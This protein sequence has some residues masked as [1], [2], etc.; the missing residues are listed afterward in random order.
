MHQLK[1]S[2]GSTENFSMDRDSISN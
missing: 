2:F 1:K